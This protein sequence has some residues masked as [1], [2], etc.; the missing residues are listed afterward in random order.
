MKVFLGI[1]EVYLGL[2][3]AA[4]VVT[5]LSLVITRPND[6]LLQCFVFILFIFLLSWGLFKI[7]KKRK[8]YISPV[9]R[10][11]IS[12]IQRSIDEATIQRDTLLHEIQNLESTLNTLNAEIES[13]YDETVVPLTHIADYE[14]LSSEEIKNKLLILRSKQDDMVRS[15]EALHVTNTGSKKIVSNQIKQ[16]LRCFNAECTNIIDHATI[17]NIDTSRSKIQ[18]AFDV[19][20]RIFAM[21]GVQLTHNYLASKL[22]ELSTIYSYLIKVEEE[23]EQKRAIREQMVEDEKVR[24]EIERE[25]KKINHDR[26]QFTQEVQR[27]MKYMQKT[28]NDVEKQLYID[29]IHELE[30]KLRELESDEKT[31]LER[32]NNAKA[33]FVYIISNIGSFGEHVFK[34]GMTRRLEP[35]DRI[36]ELSSASV[37]FPFDVHAMIFSENAPELEAT[38]HHHFEAYKMNKVNPRKEFFRVHLEDIKQLVLERFGQ[39]VN[40]IEVPNATE[41]Q[42]TLRI[43]SQITQ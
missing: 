17:K 20:N 2:L 23:K 29:K 18:R 37:P 16:I 25:K 36:A 5:S 6:W 38:L 19:N 3:D 8:N 30:Q 24:R 35:M 7:D 42:E 1:I 34:I 31:I 13:L 22:E 11:T 28:D 41:Y 27:L 26:Q 12:E 4:L 10:Q 43:E 39:T 33:G 21:D 40:F 15:G 14:H 32:E 9:Q